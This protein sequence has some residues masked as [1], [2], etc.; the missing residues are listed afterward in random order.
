MTVAL[1]HCHEVQHAFARFLQ[2][3]VIRTCESTEGVCLPHAV[4]EYDC[5]GAIVFAANGL[6]YAPVRVGKRAKLCR[7]GNSKRVLY[8]I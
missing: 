7:R 5:D 8:N 1:T 2:H 6:V 4:E 3:D